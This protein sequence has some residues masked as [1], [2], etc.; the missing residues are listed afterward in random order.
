MSSVAETHRQQGPQKI[1]CAVITV[2]DTRTLANDHSGQ[3]AVEILQRAGH[4]VVHRQI[5]PDETTHISQAVQAMLE[6][7]DVQVVLLTGGTGLSVRDV[8][9]EVV[10]PL[11]SKSLPGFGELFRML[12]YQQIGPAAMLSRALGGLAGRT[13][14]FALPG[15][16]QAVQLALEKL[17]VPELGH[18]LG[19]VARAP[20]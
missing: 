9:V 20:A 5:V 3:M 6:R 14:I 7:A 10:E 13:A 2:S 11:L 17:I 18:L 16:P 4:E 19:Q 8:T 15:S 12:S 1:R